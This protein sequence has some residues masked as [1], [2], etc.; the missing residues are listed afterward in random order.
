MSV[1]DDLIKHQIFLLRFAKS[2]SKDLIKGLSKAS[3]KVLKVATETQNPSPK[4]IKE[5]EKLMSSILSN[6]NTRQFNDLKKLIKYEAG[7]VA[8]VLAKTL[9]DDDDDVVIP[10]EKDIE[11]EVFS[12]SVINGA[13]VKLLYSSFMKDKTKNLVSVLKDNALLNKGTQEISSALN[14]LITGKFSSGAS[15]LLATVINHTASETRNEVYKENKIEKVTWVATLDNDV[16]PYCEDLDGTEW[17]VEDAEVPP[18]HYNCRCV[19]VPVN[20]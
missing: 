16:C 2:L 10:A 20:E 6:Y 12:K 9:S 14:E 13:T 11:K 7:F 8:S 1:E 4:Q 5:L 3:K 15:S 18:E 17:D 19:L